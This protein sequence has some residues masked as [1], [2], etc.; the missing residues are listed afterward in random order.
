[1][2]KIFL[3]TLCIVGISISAKC[4]GIDWWYTYYNNI[5]KT[6]CSE[7]GICSLTLSKDSLKD[8]DTI[9]IEYFND[10]YCSYCY[11]AI[12]ADSTGKEIYK[13]EGS[14][15]QHQPNAVTLSMPLGVIYRSHLTFFTVLFSDQK[16][17][18]GGKY[19]L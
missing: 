6:E 5:K 9:I 16:H 18:P 10:S 4:D 3:M 8:S 1:M 11:N 13:I 15:Y 19:L 7:A 12:L 2:K 17:S 14:I